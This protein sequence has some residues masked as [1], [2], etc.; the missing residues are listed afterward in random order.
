MSVLIKDVE[1]PAECEY[2]DFC[3]SDGECMAM[4]GDSLWEYIPNE[5]YFPDKW[6]CGDCPLIELTPHGDLIDKN[7]ME[8]DLK[9]V[10]PAAV[11]FS[12]GWI[13]NWVRAQPVIVPTEG[14]EE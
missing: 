3:T 8:E 10:N 1:I 2:C 5:P 13:D 7:A 6:K 14:G 11:L 4:G 9:T 12:R